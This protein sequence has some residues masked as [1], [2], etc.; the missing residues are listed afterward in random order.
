MPCARDE[1]ADPSLPFASLRVNARDDSVAV[2]EGFPF[3]SA[4]GRLSTSG[5]DVREANVRKNRRVPALGMTEES[6]S[7]PFTG[8]VQGK[9]GRLHDTRG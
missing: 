7:A 3:G 5:R 4:Q 9:Q 1:T 6:G 8:G 2:A